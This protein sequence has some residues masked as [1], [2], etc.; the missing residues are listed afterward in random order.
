VLARGRGALIAAVLITGFALTTGTWIGA[1][2]QLPRLPLQL[3]L[4]V[5]FVVALNGIGKFRIPRWS[6]AALGMILTLGCLFTRIGSH[7]S[8]S[9]VLMILG[10]V[11]TL[12]FVVGMGL[13]RV[14]DWQGSRR[15]GNLAMAIFLG[16]AIGQ[17]L[18]KFF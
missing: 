9:S 18:P 6:F 12:L 2:P 3:V 17:Y 1:A 10:T 16:Y 14:V 13:A 11:L 4:I 8:P 7:K 5:L 15:D